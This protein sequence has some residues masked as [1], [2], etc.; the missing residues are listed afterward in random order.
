VSLNMRLL[1]GKLRQGPLAVRRPLRAAVLGAALALCAGGARSASPVG[2]P[3]DALVV[4]CYHDILDS[5]RGAH[6]MDAVDVD[7]LVAHLAWLREAGFHPVS[8]DQ[9]VRAREGGPALPSRPVLLTF[10]DG[11]QSF[12]TRAFPLLRLYHYPALLAVVGSWIDAAPGSLVPYGDGQVPRSKFLDWQ[13]VRE[14]AH[15]GLVEIANHT[16]DQHKGIVANA[17]RSSEPAVVTRRYDAQAGSY[18]SDAEWSARIKDDLARNNAVIER[19]A[20]VRPRSV[21]WPFGAHN[22]AAVA[23]AQSLGMPITFSLDDGFLRPGDG[24]SDIPRNLMEKNPSLQDLMWSLQATLEPDAKRVVFLP[25][26]RLYSA[27]PAERERLLSTTVER[28]ARMSPSNVVLQA[29]HAGG[30]G[31]MESVYFPNRALPVRADLFNRVAWQLF[32]RAGVRVYGA[33]P[34]SSTRLDAAGLRGIYEDLARHA[35]LHGLFF[36]GA[37]AIDLA[38]D[39]ALLDAARTW[40]TPL[41]SFV[42]LDASAAGQALPQL[43]DEWDLVAIRVAR[44]VPPTAIAKLIAAANQRPRGARRLVFQA[45][46]DGPATD[47]PAL[48]ART[49]TMLRDIVREGGVSVGYGPDDPTGDFPRLSSVRPALSLRSFPE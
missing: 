1:R 46:L 25:L 29:W 27:D 7:A 24:L 21:V 38:A 6:D 15:S 26:D 35:P 8:L 14:L 5:V 37:G 10:D 16:Y 20:G 42:A 40:R 28:I 23:I 22:G 34:V 44:D 2:L 3:Q 19:E 31:E 48:S 47:A 45:V 4:L 9:I 36:D 17:E 18:E 32:T 30:S 41:R 39:R 11:Y 13:E 12:Y 33:L 49:A 43:L